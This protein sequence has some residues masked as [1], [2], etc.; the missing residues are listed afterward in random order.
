[1]HMAN[2]LDEMIGQSGMSKKALAE[3]KG[4]TPETVS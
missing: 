1:M 2:N 4:V 3:E